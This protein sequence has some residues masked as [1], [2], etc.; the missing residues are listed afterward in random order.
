M[1][2]TEG[3]TTLYIMLNCVF[4]ILLFASKVICDD[5]KWGIGIYDDTLH[6]PSQT[7]QMPVA[8]NITGPKGWVLVFFETLDPTNNATYLPLPWQVDILKTAY[9]LGIRPIVRLGQNAR[10]YRNFSDDP[11]TRLGYTKLAALYKNYV[12]ALPLPPAGG[13]SGPA[14][15][16]VLG[17]EENI[18]VEWQCH[19]SPP[20]SN[21][22]QWTAEVATWSRDIL[23]ALRPLPGIYLSVTPLAPSGPG[24]CG[25]SADAE[26][27]LVSLA[28]TA[29]STAAGAEGS[30]V[31]PIQARSRVG[32]ATGISL[33]WSPPPGTLPPRDSTGEGGG[34]CSGS[35]P[36]PPFSGT[37]SSFITYMLTCEP[38]LFG[39]TDFF[40]SHPYPGCNQA[41]S[42]NC[43]YNG[44]TVYRGE[45]ATAMPS[46]LTNTAHSP[47]SVYPV[48]ATETSW[49]GNN[50]NNSGH[51]MAEAFTNV[52]I[53]DP[54]VSAVTP[55]L[56][57]GDH[58][59]V[60]GT[61]LLHFSSFLVLILPKF[62]HIK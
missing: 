26:E 14:L 33:P 39:V 22:T 31:T 21:A 29:A 59:A 61:Y 3:A 41:P 12:A 37:S 18:C 48:F 2:S 50:Y 24:G 32:A 28:R 51:F 54:N 16:I 38:S 53:P 56:L 30:P 60:D 23:A 58:W 4:L 20:L 7:N 35:L 42:A 15:H 55:F 34:G 5:V 62:D 46:W 44:L 36:Y 40:S 11:A 6:C 45:Q 1:E 17:N 27:D 10:N 49:W 25:C 47:A 43:S 19:E 9:S 13:A 52:W 57:A 8:A